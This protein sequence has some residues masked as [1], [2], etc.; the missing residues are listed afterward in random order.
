MPNFEKARGLILQFKRDTYLFGFGVLGRVGPFCA[1]LGNRAVVVRDPFQG[2]DAFVGTVRD[3]LTS[4][5][6]EVLGTVDG[7]SPNA[8]REDLARITACLKE[9]DPELTVSFGGGSTI[10]ATKAAEILRALGGSIDDYFGTGL[11]TKALAARGKTPGTARGN[12][13][14]GEFERP[15]NEVFQHYGFEDGAKEAHR[16]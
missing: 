6:I 9:L 14:R 12:P 8:P 5:G 4:A 16:R 11:V 10:D 1:N 13:E 2:A 3:S 15:S 7:A